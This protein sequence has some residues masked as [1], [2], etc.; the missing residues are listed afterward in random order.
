MGDTVLF[1]SLGSILYCT[2]L[3]CTFESVMA[4]WLYVFQQCPKTSK[5][6]AVLHCGGG[7][8]TNSPVMLYL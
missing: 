4:W 7:N 5:Q 1:L 2:Q 8:A 3:C 6:Y